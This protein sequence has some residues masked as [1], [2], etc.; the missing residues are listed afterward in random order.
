M[1]R[2]PTSLASLVLLLAAPSPAAIA[3][4]QTASAIDAAALID[5]AATGDTSA[6]EAA[7]ASTRDP[8]QAALLRARIAASRLDEAEADRALDAWFASGDAD[9]RRRA[10]ALG[11]RA[12][13]AANAGD[14]ARARTA[15]EQWLA[16]PVAARRGHEGESME[17]GLGVAKILEA[18]PRQR[19]IG[20]TPGAIPT[21]RDKGGLVLG[22][23][24]VNGIGQAAVFDTGANLSVAS[25]STAKKLGLR[26]L[27]GNASVAT[28]SSAG[29]PTR[30]AIADRLTIAGVELANV[31]FLVLDDSQLTFPVPGGYSIDAIIGFPVFRALG[32]V[33]FDRDGGFAAGEAAG[34]VAARDNLRA[35]GAD[36]YVRARLDGVGA[37]LHLDTGAT[38]SVLLQ[39]FAKANAARLTGL[40]TGQ[41]RLAGAG[42]AVVTQPTLHWTA[43]PFDAG[44]RRLTLPTIDVVTDLA[45][46]NDADR[47]GV[48]GQDVLGRFA[49]YTI[50]FDTM[51]FA[52]GEPR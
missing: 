17:Q 49:S 12:D 48:L 29:I 42:G 47:Q 37:A 33:R 19:R 41:R 10:I 32:R 8:A 11:L 30:L 39:R 3:P 2:V 26:M 20:G 44:G 50:D 22:N 25:A 15:T 35:A 36:L 1:T 6:L 34:P 27:D 24:T 14:Y 43:V 18:A 16:L 46:M 5:G 52:L 13:V 31:I 51:G 23:V 40:A 45:G 7:L 38:H 9:L 28:S 21:T 4:A